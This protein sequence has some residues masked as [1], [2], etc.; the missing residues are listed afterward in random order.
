MACLHEGIIF[1]IFSSFGAHVSQTS[2]ARET[3]GWCTDLTIEFTPPFSNDYFISLSARGS[4]FPKN[5]LTN[6]DRYPFKG[7][8]GTLTVKRIS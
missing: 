4:D 2:I 6:P 8:W 7:V 3:D 5:G 1:G